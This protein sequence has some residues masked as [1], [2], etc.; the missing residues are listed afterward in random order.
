M[1]ERNLL[2]LLSSH[3]HILSV[4]CVKP[5]TINHED[6]MDEELWKKTLNRKKSTKGRKTW[7]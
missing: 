5:N 3:V 2:R 4:A 6:L 7:G 1:L